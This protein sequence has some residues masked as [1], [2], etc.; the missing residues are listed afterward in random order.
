MKIKAYAKINIALD[1]VGKRDDG[2]H[3][4]KMIMQTIDLYDIIDIE[5]TQSG[6]EMKCNKH[7]V[8]T[9]ERNLAYKAAKLFKDTY[10]IQDGVY[11]NLIKIFLFQQG[12]LV[13]VRMQQL[14]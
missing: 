14:F 12:L 7:Y 2:Y 9:D 1:V 6:I 8:P 11:I 3:L 4:L 13:E 10:S 5:K